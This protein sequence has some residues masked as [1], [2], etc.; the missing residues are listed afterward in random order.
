MKLKFYIRIERIDLIYRSFIVILYTIQ[1]VNIYITIKNYLL[2][3]VYVDIYTGVVIE[4]VID[5][6]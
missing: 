6:I 5:K 4:T 3:L 1:G 2:I